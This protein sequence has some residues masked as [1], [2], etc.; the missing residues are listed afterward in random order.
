MKKHTLTVKS[1]CRLNDVLKHFYL[2]A[3]KLDREMYK[4]NVLD[5]FRY[6]VYRNIKASPLLEESGI[7]KHEDFYDSSQIFKTTLSELSNRK[8]SSQHFPIISEIDRTK[9]YSA[10]FMQQISSTGLSNKLQFNISIYFFRLWA[11][12]MD[13]ITKRTHFY[14]QN[15]PQ[16]KS[17]YVRKQIDE[18]TKNRRYNDKGNVSTIMPGQPDSPSYPMAAFQKYIYKLNPQCNRLVANATWILL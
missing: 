9:S 1:W 11:E 12:Y 4:G 5:S 16:T 2:D 7:I 13:R 6:S 15:R 18:L 17:K 10:A 8:G 3:R 14:R